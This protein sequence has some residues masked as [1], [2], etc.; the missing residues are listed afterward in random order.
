MK[1]CL[2]TGGAG[3]IGANLA[4]KL[5]SLGH[6]IHILAEKN[7][8]PWRLKSILSNIHIHEIDLTYFEKINELIKTIKP[9]YIFHLASFGGLPHQQDQETIYY[10]NSNGTMNL[11]NSCKEVGFE[12]FINTGSSSE[13]GIKNTPMLETL[14][15]EPVSDYG[16]AKAAATQYCLK[17]ALFNKLPVYTVRPFSVYGDYEMPGRLISTVLTHALLDKPLQLTS[18]H[19]VRDFIYIED[20]V[21]IYLAIIKQ[22][23]QNHFVFNAGTGIETSI[24]DVITMVQTIIGKKLVIEWSSATARPWEPKHWKADASLSKQVLGWQPHYNLNK[25]LKKALAW[26]KN[27][28]EHYSTESDVYEKLSTT[29]QNQSTTS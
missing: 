16:V 12:C 23:P 9:E 14:P 22:T 17:E 29:Q 2:I 18:P 20:M 26:F 11:L 28:I 3:F 1:T 4:H 5:V 25:G 21:D 24:Q 19:N 6:R 10:V 15:L 27:H 13:Y 7:T 8:N